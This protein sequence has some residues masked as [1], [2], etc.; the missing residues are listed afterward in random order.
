APGAAPSSRPARPRRSRPRPRAGPASSWP[1]SSSAAD[2]RQAAPGRGRDR[3]R[4]RRRSRAVRAAPGSGIQWPPDRRR[5]RSSMSDQQEHRPRLFTVE[6]WSVTEPE[7]HLDALAST[8]SVFALSNGH[9]GLRGNLDEG[10]PHGIPGTYLNSVYESRPLPYGERGYGYPESGQTVI[11]VTNGRLFRLLVDDEPFDVRYGRLAKHVRRLD[12]RRGVLEREVEWYSPASDA[13][14]IRSTRLV[15][16]TQRAVA[17]FCYEVEPI[18]APLRV[19]VQSELVV[20]EAMPDL[21]PDPRTAVALESP[22]VMEEHSASG[23]EA[24]MIHH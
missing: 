6:P 16:L 1:L 10:D 11:N 17:A 15:S 22:L 3:P 13:V 24:L 21:G 4:P 19:V 7:L 8:E 18:E 2:P 23:T 12:L 14:R 5:G 20:N 9:I